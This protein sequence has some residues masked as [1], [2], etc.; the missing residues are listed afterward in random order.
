MKKNTLLVAMTL[1]MSM[2]AF[3]GQVVAD[4]PIAGYESSVEY[5]LYR[6]E[7][8]A[9]RMRAS[10][11]IGV[12]LENSG[13]DNIG[14][15][16]DLVVSRKD[17]KLMAVVSVGGFLGMGDRLVLVPYESLGLGKDADNV[18]WDVNKEATQAMPEFKY[19]GDEVSGYLTMNARKETRAAKMSD[20]AMERAGYNKAVEYSKYRSSDSAY[21]LRVSEML[22]EE[23]ENAN[24]DEVGDVDDIIIPTT[25][26]GLQAV[27]SVGGFLGMGDRLVNVPYDELR[28]GV[29][30]DE[31]YLNSA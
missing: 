15:I 18:Y 14:E 30:G 7:K 2:A 3:T 16:D 25:G 9:Y 10:D 6:G 20:E 31:L 26:R 1:T 19:D 29:E 22:G 11:V 4:S 5:S 24:G 12:D 23:I 17:D 8:S 28:V 13:G 21:K 27:V